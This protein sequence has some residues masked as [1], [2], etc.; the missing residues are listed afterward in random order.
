[1][2]KKTTPFTF[3]YVLYK[4]DISDAQDGSEAEYEVLFNECINNS[5]WMPDLSWL[6]DEL[7]H[8]DFDGLDLFKELPMNQVHEIVANVNPWHDYDEYSGEHDGGVT[9]E[10]Y[11]HRRLQGQDLK[12]FLCCYPRCNRLQGLKEDYEFELNIGSSGIDAMN[13]EVAVGSVPKELRDLTIEQLA[14]MESYMK[15]IL[16]RYY[17]GSE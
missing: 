4:Y 14:S 3:R 17:E 5:F 8:T 12:E 2:P 15:S 1:M 11:A 7:H 13:W 16:T 10:D 9:W 6:D